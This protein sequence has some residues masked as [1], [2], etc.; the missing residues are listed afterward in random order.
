MILV[1]S[2]VWISYFRGEENSDLERLIEQDL[3]CTNELIL[4]ELIPAL[5]LNQQRGIIESLESLPIIPLIIDWEV[6]RQMQAEN[7]KKGVNKVGIPD[8]MILQQVIEEN[9]HLLTL[10]KHFKLM[11]ASFDFSLVG[12]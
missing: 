3:I 2:S 9:L 11:R 5:K 1:D 7:L 10:D 6:M 12:E 4:T 8:L